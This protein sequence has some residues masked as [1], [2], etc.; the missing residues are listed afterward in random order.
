MGGEAFSDQAPLSWNHLQV[1]DRGAD[2][3]SVVRTR[4]KTFFFDKAYN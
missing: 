3:L 4:L 1:W 2:T